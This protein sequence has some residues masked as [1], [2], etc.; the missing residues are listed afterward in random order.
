MSMQATTE[1]GSAARYE[2]LAPAWDVGRP[3]RAVYELELAGQLGHELLDVGCG[4]GVHALWLA[5]RGH[6]VCG[7]DPSA[8]AIERACRR[9]R[10]EG[11][12]GAEFVVGELVDVGRMGR[13]FDCAL[14]AGSFHRLAVASREAYARG[15]A[16]AVRSGGKAFV[17]CFADRE[18]GKGGP[19]RVGQE[20]L[21]R[22]FTESGG[23][24]WVVEAVDQSVIE[25]R[26]FP[27]GAA[28]WLLR[29]RRR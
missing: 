7:V 3:Q 25:S 17:L 9:G 24:A 6:L 2:P 4:S 16:R 28:A 15:L 14:D 1:T 26:L 13:Q 18:R 11:T 20:E 21:R 22:L 29:A 27:G 12:V 8:R 5:S 19:L 10:R 23:G